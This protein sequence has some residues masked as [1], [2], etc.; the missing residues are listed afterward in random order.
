MSVKFRQRHAIAA[1]AACV[2]LCLPPRLRAQDTAATHAPASVRMDGDEFTFTSSDGSTELALRFRAQLIA[3]LSVPPQGD[4]G[5]AVLDAQVRRARVRIDGSLLDPRLGV[6]MQ[7]GLTRRDLAG[8]DP[9]IASVLLD[10]K[11]SWQQTERLSFTAGLGKLPANRQQ[12]ISSGRLQFAERS[13][14]NS[15]FTIDRDMMVMAAYESDGRLPWSWSGAISSGEGRA[16]SGADLGL[17]YTTRLDLRPLGAFADGNEMREGDLAREPAPRLLLGVVFSHNDRAW[18]TRGQGGD[19]LDEPRDL[20]TVMADAMLKY[21]G[22]SLYLEGAHRVAGE[23]LAVV[24]PGEDPE[25]RGGLIQLSYLTMA[26]WEPALRLAR[27]E[28]QDDTDASQASLN[29]TRYIDAHRIK[30]MLEAGREWGGAPRLNS[31]WMVRTSFEVG[32]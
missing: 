21:Q 12:N 32:I 15:T 19:P 17:A 28:M 24:A 30:Y 26:G 18:R 6:S 29:L 25:G 20:T 22:W 11:V 14:V 13:L 8:G 7:A 4:A 16:S 5:E 31:R 23:T 3:T 2:C 10:A 9:G 27:V 1:L